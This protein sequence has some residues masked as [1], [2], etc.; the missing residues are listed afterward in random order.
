MN[1]AR[2]VPQPSPDPNRE[3]R[4]LR[5]INLINKHMEVER[6]KSDKHSSIPILYVTDGMTDEETTIR[7][8]EASPQVQNVARRLAHDPLGLLDGQIS[9][10]ATARF[11]DVF[12]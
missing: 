8:D 1:K 12:A 3:P 6:W 2:I 10:D 4:P 11:R 5:D 7:W 9:V